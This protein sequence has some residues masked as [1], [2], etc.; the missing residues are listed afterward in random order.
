MGGCL[1]IGGS[2]CPGAQGPLHEHHV[3][4]LP[5]LEARRRLRTY[6]RETELPMQLN[7]VL[8]LCPGND[9]DHLPPRALLALS[10]EFRKQEP[11]DPSARFTIRQVD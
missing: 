2:F 6:M 5:E 4:P 10:Y 11:T 3:Y 8:V 9:G 1:F 7:G